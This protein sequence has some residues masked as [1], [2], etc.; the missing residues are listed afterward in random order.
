M[1][2][3]KRGQFYIL[4]AV[5]AIVIITGLVTTANYARKVKQPVQFY[6]LSEDFEAETTKIIDYGVFQSMPEQEIIR[7]IE[8]FAT[9]YLEYAQKKDPNLQLVYIYGDSKGIYIDNYAFEDI[10]IEPAS[11]TRIGTGAGSEKAISRVTIHYEG[12]EFTKEIGEKMRYFENVKRDIQSP[13]GFVR[14]EIAGIVHNFNLG[15]TEAFYYV[16]VTKG[17]ESE[18]HVAKTPEDLGDVI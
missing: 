2:N 17:L 3:D 1:F 18:I 8:V 7:Q 6:D 9:E 11:G 5:L 14:V 4:F 13:G 12:K 16:V 10:S 15:S